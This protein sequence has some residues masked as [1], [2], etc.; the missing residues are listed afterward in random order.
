MDINTQINRIAFFTLVLAFFTALL[1]I[2][3]GFGVRLEWWG[4]SFGFKLLKTVFVVGLINGG[5]VIIVSAVGLVKKIPLQ[6]IVLP[7]LFVG[8]LVVTIPYF[9]VREFRKI[10][11]FADASTN[12]E[13]PPGFVLLAE[14]RKTTAGNS[15]LFS[16]NEAAA[17]Q[18]KYFPKL[19]SITIPHSV[20]EVNQKTRQILLDMGLSLA[21]S[22]GSSERI[23]ATDT[24]FWFGFKDDVVI[25]FK[26]LPDGSTHVDV[27]SVSR[28]GKL[29]GGANAKRVQ[30]ILAALQRAQ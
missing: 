17:A 29:D 18:L 21:T 13:N 10:P 30:A 9:N 11:T 2:I 4:F 19:Q 7:A 20:A 16:V 6:R 23:E 15:L 24:S 22:E 14:E 26:A 28:V 27:R 25:V 3:A 12:L 8:S 5:I 1:A